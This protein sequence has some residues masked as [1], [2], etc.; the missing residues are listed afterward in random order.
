MG[1]AVLMGIGVLGAAVG[2][3]GSGG[4]AIM[5]GALDPTPIDP[6]MPQ[7]I[8]RFGGMVQPIGKQDYEF[9]S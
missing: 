3:A 5:A 4:E 7:S 1:A 6:I 9:W 2:Q 8:I